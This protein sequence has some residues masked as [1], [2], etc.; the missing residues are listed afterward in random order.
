MSMMRLRKYCLSAGALLL[1][2]VPA[3]A[4][5]QA[6]SNDTG[7]GPVL[8]NIKKTRTVRV[9][10]RDASPPFSF[11]DQA[12]RPIGYSLELC[13]AIVEQIAT[14]VDEPGTTNDVVPKAGLKIEFVKVT[15]ENRIAMVVDHRIDL[16][17]GSTTANF[18]RSP[19]V[20]PAE[21]LRALRLGSR[22]D[23]AAALRGPVLL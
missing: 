19:A 20:F 14:E 3:G 23:H 6:P 2:F 7:L 18:E 13:E 8:A 15:A 11:L 5:A 21:Q 12:G 22:S 1:A 9:G 10:Y 17:C 16:E 4:Q